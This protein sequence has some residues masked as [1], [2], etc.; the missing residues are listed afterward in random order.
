S[1][2]GIFY[3]SLTADFGAKLSVADFYSLNSSFQNNATIQAADPLEVGIT[4]PYHQEIKSGKNTMNLE[5]IP[6]YKNVLMAPSAGE[7][8]TVLVRSTEL[9]TTLSAPVK[10][11]LF[12]SGRLDLGADQSLSASSTGDDDLSGTRTGITFTPTQ[13]LDLKGEKTLTGELSFLLNNANG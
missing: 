8:R 3:R 11:D 13:L 5:M 4:L 6:G 7:T 10:K 2:L 1:V 9:A 12:L